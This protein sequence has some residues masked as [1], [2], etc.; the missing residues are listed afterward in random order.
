MRN[1]EDSKQLP[2]ASKTCVFFARNQYKGKN[3]KQRNSSKLKN[4]VSTNNNRND[5][6]TYFKQ[7]MCHY[8]G[9]PTHIIPNYKAFAW[10]KLNG[11]FK[12]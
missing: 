11:V 2:A 12:P 5:K 8:C 6:S 1:Y 3:W 10:D 7:L 4:K 9:K